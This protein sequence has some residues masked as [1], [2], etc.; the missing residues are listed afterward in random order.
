VKKVKTLQLMLS[1]LG[2]ALNSILSALFFLAIWIFIFAAIGSDPQM[3]RHVREGRVI[4][5]RW[6]F[7]TIVNA[8]MLLFRVATGDSW[9]DLIYDC[10]VEEPFCSPP[11]TEEESPAFHQTHSDC[12]RGPVAYVFFIL[13]WIGCNYIFLPLFVATLI[14]YFSEAQTDSASLFTGEECD[15]FAAVWSEFSNSDTPGTMSIESLRPFIERL[16][17]KQH[18][19]GFRV[20]SDRERFKMVW[21]RI[22][23]DPT[24]FPQEGVAIIEKEDQEEMGLEEINR[25]TIVKGFGHSQRAKKICEYVYAQTRVKQGKEVDFKYCAKVLVVFMQRKTFQDPLSSADLVNRG[26]ALQ[27][28]MGML[29]KHK[30]PEYENWKENEKWKALAIHH[31]MVEPLTKSGG[32]AAKGS[33]EMLDETNL[34]KILKAIQIVKLE[35]S[36]PDV[37][38][39][40]PLQKPAKPTGAKRAELVRKIDSMQKSFDQ[41]VDD[42]IDNVLYGGKNLQGIRSEGV[43]D[44]LLDR[45]FEASAA[46]F[47]KKE[48]KKQ[49]PWTAAKL[50]KKHSHLTKFSDSAKHR[51]EKHHEEVEFVTSVPRGWLNSQKKRKPRRIKKG[52]VFEDMTQDTKETLGQL[53]PPVVPPRSS[54]LALGQNNVVLDHAVRDM[55]RTDTWKHV[56]A[57]THAPPPQEPATSL[58][59][60]KRYENQVEKQQT[61]I[62]SGVFGCSAPRNPPNNA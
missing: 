15:K 56:F 55:F 60:R 47:A 35:L 48:I 28:F 24:K 57:Q 17:A 23:T 36:P 45:I 1:T 38:G 5:S 6:N 8:M 29:S 39:Q 42:M 21:A 50:D 10:A 11:K 7:E 9:F 53:L 2:G 40:D 59:W 61:G 26:A 33:R 58:S 37:P 41:I 20:S 13:F 16:Q 32:R 51:D 25:D 27:Q 3:F 19:C 4:S 62:F 46:K 49:G 12:G 44:V 31:D 54:S 43:V 18:R 14:D 30:Q 34:P 52:E 22:M